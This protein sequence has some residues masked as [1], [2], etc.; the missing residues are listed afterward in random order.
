MDQKL[1]DDLYTARWF[2]KEIMENFN[3][4]AKVKDLAS[5]QHMH[6]STMIM[7]EKIKPVPT[8]EVKIE[9]VKSVGSKS[10]WYPRAV[11][12]PKRMKTRGKYAKG[13]P[14]GAVVHFTAG[15]DGAAKT[16]DGGIKDGYAYLCIQKDGTIVQ[17]HPISEWGYHAGESAWKHLAK[18]LV[19]AVSD[20]LIGIEIN[21]AGRVEPQANGTYKTWF[22]TYLT[23]DQVRYTPG[24][25]NQLKGYYEKYTPAQEKTLAEVLLWLK[26]QAPAIFDFDFVLG[27]DEVAGPAGIGRWRKN[28]PGAALSMTM[29]EFR[30]HLKKLWV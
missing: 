30:D 17:A 5:S 18:K 14:V 8:P 19:G 22:G 27:H 20:D 9:P 4:A 3:N 11:I 13:Y 29:P 16:I 28:D 21:C 7:G 25:A 26:S 1:K 2:T 23:A 12:H 24:K 15:R 6:L 10:D